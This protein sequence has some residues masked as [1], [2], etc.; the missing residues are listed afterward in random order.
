MVMAD[1]AKVLLMRYISENIVRR[2]RMCGWSE[3]DMLKNVLLN[4]LIIFD[5]LD[6]F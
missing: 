4:F 5:D 6:N 2:G 1:M 3:L